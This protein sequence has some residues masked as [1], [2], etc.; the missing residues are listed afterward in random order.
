MSK[1]PIIELHLL[2]YLEK[3][4]PDQCPN[5]SDT[6]RD[7]WMNVGSVQVVRHLKDIYEQQNDNILNQ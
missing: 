6:D 7:I 4:F 3:V 1:L 5:V 2:E